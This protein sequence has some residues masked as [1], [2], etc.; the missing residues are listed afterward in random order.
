[1]EIADATIDAMQRSLDARDMELVREPETASRSSR[2]WERWETEPWDIEP[3]KTTGLTRHGLPA[4]PSKP[5][6]HPIKTTEPPNPIQRTPSS[7]TSIGVAVLPSPERRETVREPGK[8]ATEGPQK[9]K[10][11]EGTEDQA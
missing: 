3:E 2:L 6:L 5:T 11:E 7:S 9:E 8:A 10:A 1:M 4:N